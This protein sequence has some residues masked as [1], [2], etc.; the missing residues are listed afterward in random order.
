MGCG[1]DAARAA[2]LCA[3]CRSALRAA[4]AVG[5]V[6]A[7]V[8]YAGPA[9]AMV[10][11]LKFEGRVAV[12]DAMAAFM[13]ARAPDGLLA[14][15]GPVGAC[16]PD[17]L[18]APRGPAGACAPGIEPALVPVP[19][20]P[21]HRRRRG[22]D[23]AS[24][25]ARALGRRTGLPVADCL[26]RA[27]GAPQ[28]GR[29]RRERMAGVDGRIRVRSQASIPARALVVDDVVT[30]GATVAACVRALREAGARE[31]RALAFAATEGR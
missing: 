6:W 30:T 16:A 8:A 3:E 19:A 12:A 27:G 23:H 29:G 11:A 26:I 10:R 31:V 21:R 9:A 15:D 4:P 25:L 18:L 2:P 17:G 28:V 7:A 20:H 24:A 1:A 13:A 14:P 22:F 5:D